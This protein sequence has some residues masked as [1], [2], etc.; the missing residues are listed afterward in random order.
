MTEVKAHRL[1][2]VK[3]DGWHEHI[4]GR[5]HYRQLAGDP[6]WRHGWISFDTV[7]YNPDDG[8]VYCGLNSIDGDLLYRFDPATERF[9]CL[10]T[11]QWTDPFDVKIHRTLLYNGRNRCFYFGT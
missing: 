5:W 8:G 7:T 11:R 1:R 4:A 2:D 9:T 10:E 3:L 6:A